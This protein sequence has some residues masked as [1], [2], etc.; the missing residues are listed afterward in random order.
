MEV[1]EARCET[2]DCGA[3]EVAVEGVKDAHDSGNWVGFGRVGR[4]GGEGGGEGLWCWWDVV[5]E[6]VFDRGSLLRRAWIWK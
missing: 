4:E 1:D 3:V 5:S 6:R 2:V